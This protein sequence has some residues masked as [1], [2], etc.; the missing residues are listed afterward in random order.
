M[1]ESIGLI[2]WVLIIVSLLFYI[3][4]LLTKSWVAYCISGLALL[5]PSLYFLGAENWSRIVTLI[6][7]LPFYQAFLT[8]K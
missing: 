4:G 7:L 5:L 2:F 6:P 1:G 3:K 8:K